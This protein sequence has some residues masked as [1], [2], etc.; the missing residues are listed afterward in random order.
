MIALPSFL[1]PF[2]FSRPRDADITRKSARYRARLSAREAERNIPR[3]LIAIIYPESHLGRNCP[4]SAKP[5]NQSQPE[6]IRRSS[7]RPAVRV[8]R[9]NDRRFA[10]EKAKNALVT[11]SL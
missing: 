11:G 5:F 10:S 8:T 3:T 4:I 7:A 2:R 6:A 1:P 9:Q